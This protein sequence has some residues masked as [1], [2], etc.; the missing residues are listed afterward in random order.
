MTICQKIKQN[1]KDTK[2]KKTISF[3]YFQSRFSYDF[4]NDSMILLLTRYA[5]FSIIPTV[6]QNNMFKHVQQN[7]TWIIQFYVAWNKAISNVQHRLQKTTTIFPAVKSIFTFLLDNW[8]KRNSG[9]FDKFVFHKMF[10]YV[11]LS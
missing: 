4:R 3:I 9:F 7:D 10:L 5:V 6:C 8:I 1:T 11:K 2:H